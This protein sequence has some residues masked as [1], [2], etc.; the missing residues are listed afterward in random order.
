MVQR[1]AHAELWVVSLHLIVFNNNNSSMLGELLGLRSLED[2]RTDARLCL[3]Y[4]IVHGLVAVPL[5]SYVV[6]SQVSTRHSKSRP[7]AFRQIHLVADYYKYSFPPP[8]PPPSPHGIVQWNR[9]PQSI[10]LL[11]DIDCFRL[12]VSSL[13]YSMPL[14]GSI[15]FNLLS[16]YFVF[17]R[18]LTF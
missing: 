5:P 6:H 11:P 7:L 10:A 12:A 1:R 18:L 15:D 8:P 14:T 17:I 2:R 4:K 9:L 3:F 16:L 13:T